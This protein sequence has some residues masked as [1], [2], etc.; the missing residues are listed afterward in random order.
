MK[1]AILISALIFLPALFFGREALF[2]GEDYTISAEYNDQA[3]PGDAVFVRMTF[4]QS[5]KK[6]K[7]SKTDF[8]SSRAVLQL[9]TDGKQSRESEFFTISKSIKSSRTF[10]AGIPLSTWWNEDTK[11][12]LKIIYTAGNSKQMEFELPFS[13]EKKEFVTEAIDLDEQ[14]SGIKT[15]TSQKRMEQIKKL[16]GILETVD[17][18]AVF[19]LTPFSLPTDKTRRTAFFADRREYRYSNGK[20]ST[21]LHYGI[22]FGIPEGSEVSACAEGKVVLAETRITTGWTVV[23]EHLPG[24]YSLYYHMSQLKVKEGDTVR[25]GQNIGLSGST[26]LA[27]GPH[28]HWEMRLNK[29]AVNP[30]F[31]TGDFSFS[32][33]N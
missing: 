6:A 15:D 3:F 14:N 16:N 32:G 12:S 28:L 30:D 10:L 7:A 8:S 2:T 24:L 1:K 23:I 18:S 5:A 11:C 29:E 21:G 31:F 19:Q 26:G 20:S 4:T 17:S 9:F 27:T 33:K 13:I 22:D 25:Q